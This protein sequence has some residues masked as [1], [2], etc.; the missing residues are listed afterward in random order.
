MEKESWRRNH[1][2]GN[3][4]E[5]SLRNHRGVIMEEEPWRRN[6]GWGIMEDES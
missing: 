2:S 3:M 4:E 1:G 6:R 5:K